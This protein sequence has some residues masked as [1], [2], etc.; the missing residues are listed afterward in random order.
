MNEANYDMMDIR[1]G[2]EET[3]TTLVGPKNSKDAPQLTWS[4]VSPKQTQ[5]RQSRMDVLVG[6]P[7]TLK[8][9]K[10]KTAKTPAAVLQCFITGNIVDKI[11]IQL[12]SCNPNS[13]N[14]NNH[15][16]R[17]NFPVPS[18]FPIMYGNSYNLNNHVIRTNFSACL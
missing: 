3:Y 17:T 1:S 12:N 15:V 5:G 10:A 14:S 2:N 4:N 11:V 7:D 8:S 16:I 6:V 18:N 13:Y 9:R